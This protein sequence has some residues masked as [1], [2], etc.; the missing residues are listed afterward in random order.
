MVMKRQ[1]LMIEILVM[2]YKIDTFPIITIINLMVENFQ[3]FSPVKYLKQQLIIKN[4]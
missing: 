3:E 1:S 4:E 2:K